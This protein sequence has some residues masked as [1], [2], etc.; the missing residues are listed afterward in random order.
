MP[1]NV[2]SSGSVIGLDALIETFITK[3]VLV[4]FSS[5][6]LDWDSNDA[7]TLISF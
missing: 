3:F 1:P 6:V 5:I 7:S 2:Q 4:P